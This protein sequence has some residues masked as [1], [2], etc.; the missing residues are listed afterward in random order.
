MEVPYFLDFLLHI[1]NWAFDVRSWRCILGN[2]LVVPALS[3]IFQLEGVG[4]H[5]VGNEGGSWQCPLSWAHTGWWHFVGSNYHGWWQCPNYSISHWQFAT[6]IFSTA[7]SWSWEDSLWALQLRR[8]GSEHIVAMG[9]STIVE[10]PEIFAYERKKTKNDTKWA[11]TIFIGMQF[12]VKLD[13]QKN[14]L[15]IAANLCHIK[16]TLKLDIPLEH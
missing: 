14:C 11:N 5:I 1:K 7:W 9:K 16:T 4:W 15:N 8:V 10:S 2:N 6:V 12:N 3:R 13:V